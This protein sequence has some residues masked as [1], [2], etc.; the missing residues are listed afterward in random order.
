MSQTA[1]RLYEWGRGKNIVVVKLSK[2]F[3]VSDIR[4]SKAVLS[5]AKNENK[6]QNS[7]R[8]DMLNFILNAKL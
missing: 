4:S 3:L 7:L 5:F 2:C 8:S 1:V 6:I